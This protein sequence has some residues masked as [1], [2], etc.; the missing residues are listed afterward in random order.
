MIDDLPKRM[1]DRQVDGLPQ[2][3]A[4][5]LMTDDVVRG[6]QLILDSASMELGEKLELQV[7]LDDLPS[8]TAAVNW[9]ASV[10]GSAQLS[11]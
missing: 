7:D 1:Q 2:V 9:L 11:E 10:V 4:L 8:L 5:P 3:D 6:L